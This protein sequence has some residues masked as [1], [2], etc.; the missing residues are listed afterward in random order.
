MD[1]KSTVWEA[2]IKKAI[3]KVFTKHLSILFVTFFPIILKYTENPFQT[4][5]LTNIWSGEILTHWR[6]IMN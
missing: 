1:D 3:L 5:G 4:S 6:P 2:I